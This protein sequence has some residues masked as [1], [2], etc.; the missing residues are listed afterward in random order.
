MRVLA[1][2]AVVGVAL[3]VVLGRLLA[4]MLFGVAPLDPLTFAGVITVLLLTGLLAVAG[5]AWKATRVDPVVA[6]RSE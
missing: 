1:I 4:S 5:P 3:S 6:L 2:G